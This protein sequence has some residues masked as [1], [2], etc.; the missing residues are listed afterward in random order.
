MGS[1]CEAAVQGREYPRRVYTDPAFELVVSQGR[2]SRCRIQKW[3]RK[4]EIHQAA[5]HLC[6]RVAAC[7][8]DSRAGGAQHRYGTGVS[9]TEERDDQAIRRRTQGKSRLAQTAKGP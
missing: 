2:K 9:N 5:V 4:N 6:R 7:A 1:G 3:R 8:F